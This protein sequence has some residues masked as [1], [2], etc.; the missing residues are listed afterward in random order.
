MVDKGDRADNWTDNSGSSMFTY[1]VQR[2]ID[3][4]LPPA[5]HYADVATR[6]YRS[7]VANA[8]IHEDGLLDLYSACD[9][10]CVQANYADYINYKKTVNAKEPIAGFL[11]ATATVGR[12]E[13]EK[14]RKR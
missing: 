14:T 6:D 11:W 3:L 9:G 8:K 1:A 13:L 4:G 2:G 7:I 5:K 12:T 10:V